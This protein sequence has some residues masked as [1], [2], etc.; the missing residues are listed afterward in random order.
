M[1]GQISRLPVR[2]QIERV[3]SDQDAMYRGG[4]RAELLFDSM[5]FT[6]VNAPAFHGEAAGCIDARHSDFGVKVER[7]K[8][9]CDVLAIQV[10]SAQSGIQVVEWDVMISGDHDLRLGKPAQKRGCGFEFAMA[11]ALREIPRYD[12]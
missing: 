2:R 4:K 5:S 7:L 6:A 9:G 12:H 3:V 1:P 8:I 11:C 10:E